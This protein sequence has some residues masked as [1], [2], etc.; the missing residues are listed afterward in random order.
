MWRSRGKIIVGT[1][2]GDLHDIGKN[3]V[4]MMLEGAGFD[5]INMGTDVTIERIME[6]ME[7]NRPMS[8][9]CQPS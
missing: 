9:A 5:V 3:I 6:Y 2:R 4:A 1:V 7:K 8:S